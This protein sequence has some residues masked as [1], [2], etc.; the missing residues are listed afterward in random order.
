MGEGRLPLEGIRV[1]ELAQILAGPFCGTLMA[2][3][4]AEVIKVEMP[5]RG[6]DIRRMGPAERG[7]GYW[8]A[9]DNRNKRVITLDLHHPKG[10]EII[11]RL[12]PLVDVVTENFRPGTLERW[13]IGWEELSRINPQLVM[14]RITTFGQTGPWRNG[15]GFAAIGSAFGGTWYINGPADRPPTRPTP[16][17]PDYMTGLF[18][19]FGVL[20]A[21]RHRDATG[22]GQWIDAALYE[23]TFRTLEYTAAWYGRQGVV[24]ER[25]GSQ[26]I[27]WP[28]GACQTKDGRWVA[29][30]APAQH[31][32]ERVCKMLGQPDLPQDERYATPEARGIHMRAFAQEVEHWFA[33]RTYEEASK[34][35]E[36]HQVPYS[37]IMSMA[38]IFT[39]PH[40]REREM[41]IDVP[42][43]TLGSL[44]QPGVVPKLSRTPG[45][46]THAG[47]PLGQDTEDILREFLQISPTDL[48]ELR[49]QGVI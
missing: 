38:D 14:A 41:I 6:D 47:P 1:L 24:R 16:V 40:F 27:G 34:A 31:L 32:F 22:E 11:R 45:R 26:H 8:W 28:G 35:L 5:G 2:E 29:Y 20:A 30:T 46:V 10:Q 36:E 4:G 7:V 49:Q 17:Y 39:E 44:P 12:V 3:F 37:P 23:A 19:A 42:E 48:T 9:L 25:G 21:L 13:H 43:A 18:T 33:A 15:P